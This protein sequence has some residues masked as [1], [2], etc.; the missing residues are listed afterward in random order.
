M[1]MRLSQ[2]WSCQQHV[3]NRP[4][5][6]PLFLRWGMIGAFQ[7]RLSLQENLEEVPMPSLI[8]KQAVVVGAGMAGL[9][10]A[11]SLADFFERVIVLENDALPKE[12][13]ARPGTPQ[14]RHVHALLAGGLKALSRLFP[15]FDKS[16]S[17]AG[18]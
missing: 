8:G 13:A 16:L 5:R 17:Q 18:A 1:K 11:R 3:Q 15:D 14:C 12:A 6:S 9:T 4:I 10:A 2:R 7:F